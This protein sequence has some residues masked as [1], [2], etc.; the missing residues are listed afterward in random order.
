MKI[1][2]VHTKYLQRGGED[3][4]YEAEQQLLRSRGHQVRPLLFDNAQIASLGAVYTG[5]SSS[6]SPASYRRVAA[7]IAS[8]R[9]D[10]VN[11]HNFFPLATSAV[12]DAAAR[13]GVPV[14]QTLH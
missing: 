13:A 10:I 5:L 14:V 2:S 8:W 3:E 1:L 6:W 12:H 4:V 11:V 7:E 9:P